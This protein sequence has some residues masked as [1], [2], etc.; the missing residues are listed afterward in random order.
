MPGGLVAKRG[1]MSNN[2]VLVSLWSTGL[3]TGLVP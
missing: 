2:T 1:T 3:E